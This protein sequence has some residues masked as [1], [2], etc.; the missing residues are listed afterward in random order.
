MVEWFKKSAEKLNI[1]KSIL[2]LNSLCQLGNFILFKKNHL[3]SD[4]CFLNFSALNLS[5][6]IVQKH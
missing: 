4:C 3:S 5:M 1:I 2:V 6:H